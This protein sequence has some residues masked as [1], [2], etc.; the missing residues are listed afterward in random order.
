MHATVV[1]V[2]INDEEPS[3]AALREQV[4]PRVSQMPGFVA[5]YWTRKGNT[6]L[7]M[8]VWESEEAANAAADMVRSVAPEGVT[9]D[10]V[11]VREV[12]ASA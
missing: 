7:S 3:L 2:T 6:G 5:A 4:V 12:V 9:V 1:N 10:N 8:G 11:E